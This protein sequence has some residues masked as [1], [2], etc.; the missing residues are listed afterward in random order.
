M[1]DEAGRVA[2]V[3]GVDGQDFIKREE[4]VPSQM[5]GVPAEQKAPLAVRKLD[6]CSWLKLTFGIE[7]SHHR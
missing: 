2:S 5:P 1:V 4:V 7:L 3:G 6:H